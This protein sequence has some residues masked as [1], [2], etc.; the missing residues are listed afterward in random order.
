MISA[1]LKDELTLL[2]NSDLHAVIGIV[3]SKLGLSWA[4][5]N[6]YDAESVWA[7]YCEDTPMSNPDWEIIS[8]SAEWVGN[9]DGSA[10]DIAYDNMRKCVKQYLI[11]QGLI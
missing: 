10:M 5:F 6:R 4:Y 11:D 3:A 7:D 1:E 2:N 8:K 9:F